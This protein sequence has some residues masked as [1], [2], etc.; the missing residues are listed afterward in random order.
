MDY[1]DAKQ[2]FFAFLF[3]L[4]ASLLMVWWDPM[5]K[6]DGAEAVEAE[7]YSLVDASPPLAPCSCEPSFARTRDG[8]FV[9][10]HG[11]YSSNGTVKLRIQHT[12]NDGRR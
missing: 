6:G 9:T 12:T 8:S 3:C 10:P 7:K 11:T 2:L 5:N 4:V 1:E